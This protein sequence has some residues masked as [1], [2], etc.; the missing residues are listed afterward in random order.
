MKPMDIRYDETCLDATGCCWSIKPDH[1]DFNSEEVEIGAQLACKECNRL[2]EL[3][4][5]TGMDP[6]PEWY[7]L[8]RLTKGKAQQK[9]GDNY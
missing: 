3:R 7:P 8:K 1:L 2:F 4:M 9:P 6:R 5:S